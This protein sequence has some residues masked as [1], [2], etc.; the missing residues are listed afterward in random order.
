MSFE[1]TG[2]G[3]KIRFAADASLV[4]YA[5]AT[6]DPGF[7]IPDKI[8]LTHNETLGFKA[9]AAG[10]VAEM[11]NIT[12]TALYDL[13]DRA[14]ALAIKGITTAITFEHSLSGVDRDT[15]QT[16]TV[17]GWLNGFVPQEATTNNAPEAQIEIGF[18]GGIDGVVLADIFGVLT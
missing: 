17:Q 16:I 4:L 12:F 9:Y 10:D 6:T 13:T 3:I 14:K 1:R 15:V 7:N 11:D 8:E 18:A 5:K 2:H